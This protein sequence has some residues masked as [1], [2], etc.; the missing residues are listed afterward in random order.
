MK[1][2]GHMPLWFSLGITLIGVGAFTAFPR[3]NGVHLY[4]EPTKIAGVM[5]PLFL[6]AAFIERAVEVG[7]SPW[8]DTQADKLSDTADAKKAHAKAKAAA[9]AA[10]MV[11]CSSVDPA[12]SAAFG[13]ATIVASA[14][15]DAAAT[16]AQSASDAVDA[17]ARYKGK[18][19]QYG[20]CHCPYTGSLARLC[21]GPRTLKFLSPAAGLS[22][23]P[24]AIDV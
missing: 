10:A 6:G 4:V 1:D 21:R 3:L 14:A 15:T 19:K 12:N 9:T 2:I 24:P 11:V 7:I 22:E 23:R 18:T 13:A 17:F 8:G 5:A 16:A 20:L